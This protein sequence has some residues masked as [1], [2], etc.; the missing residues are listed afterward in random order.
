MGGGRGARVAAE[1]IHSARAL[2]IPAYEGYGLS[3]CASVVSMNTPQHDQPGSCGKPLSHLQIQLAEDGELWVRGNSALGYIG[4][5]LTDEW[6]ATGDLATLDE[7]GFLCIV[8]RKKI[9][10]LLPLGATSHRN[11]LS[12]TRKFGYRNAVSWWSAMMRWA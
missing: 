9:S 12:L 5:P 8:G 6:L 10:S 11:G 3:E 1:L 2:G 7:Q 4:E